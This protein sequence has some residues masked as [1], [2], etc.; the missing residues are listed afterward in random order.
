[1]AEPGRFISAPAVKC[2]ATVIGRAVR[3]GMWWY[4]LDDGV[5]GSFSGQMY[6]KVRYPLEVFS[7]EAQL[8]RSVLAGPTCDS[9]DLIVEDVSLPTL[10][11]GDVVVGHMMGAYTAASATEFNSFQKTPIIVVNSKDVPNEIDLPKKASGIL[12]EGWGRSIN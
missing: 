7:D 9:I 5:Y 4:Y 12:E 6:D 3:S 10:Q 8:V 11:I 1:M 2:A